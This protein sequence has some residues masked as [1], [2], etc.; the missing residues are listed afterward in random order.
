MTAPLDGY[1]RNTASLVLEEVEAQR[2]VMTAVATGGPRI[3]D[4]N[5]EYKDRRK[6]IRSALDRLALPDPNAYDDLWGWYGKWSSGDLPTYV[7]RRQYLRELYAPLISQLQSIESGVLPSMQ[8]E[9]TGWERVDR[10]IDKMRL[11]VATARHEEDHQRVGLLAREVLI[12]LAQAVYAPERHPTT[13]G[14]K[15]SDTDAARMLEAYVAV[16]LAGQAHEGLRRHA[17]AALTLAVGLQHSRTANFRMAALC[18]EATSAVV[19]I[20]AIVSGR[21]DP[22]E[23]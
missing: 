6:R 19:N 11:Q 10:G 16:E 22:I 2:N 14:V 4:V 18:A 13:D 9:P 7:S 15:P 17:K 21:R 1:D 12:S 5:G 3:D 23:P 20:V 8:R